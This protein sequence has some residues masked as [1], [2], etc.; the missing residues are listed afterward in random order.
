VEKGI[1]VNYEDVLENVKK[2]DFIDE[3]RDV[4]PLKKATDAH[5]LDNSHMTVKEQMKW[6]ADKFE[7]ILK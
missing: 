6:F 3:N 7:S 2:R 5:L 1:K 4:A